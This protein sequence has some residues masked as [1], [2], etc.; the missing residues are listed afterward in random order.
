MKIQKERILF[1]ILFLFSVFIA[2]NVWYHIE[3]KYKDPSIIGQYSKNNY[4]GFNDILRYLIFLIIPTFIILGFKY[5]TNKEFLSEL[6]FFFFF[7]FNDKFIVYNI[8]FLNV[9]YFFII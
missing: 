6:S 7:L 8:F 1:T 5:F 9:I 2:S 3:I 4:H